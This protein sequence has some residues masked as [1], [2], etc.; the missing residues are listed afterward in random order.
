[1]PARSGQPRTLIRRRDYP[2]STGTKIFVSS[3]CTR[4][5]VQDSGTVI[6]RSKMHATLKRNFQVMPGA[7][8]LQLLIQHIPDKNEHLVRYYG[9][10][11]NR[12]RGA[13]K[14]EAE[15]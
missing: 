3:R 6:Y 8:W 2:G 9:A 11:S 7:Q 12:Y 10:Y 5:A 1:M 15:E 13:H 4:S 14:D